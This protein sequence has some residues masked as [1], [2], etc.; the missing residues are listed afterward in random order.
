MDTFAYILTIQK[1]T[2]KIMRFTFIFIFL[3]A[4]NT[5]LSAQN[6]TLVWEDQFNGATLD[7]SKWNIENREGIWNTG[8][9]KEFQHYK[10]ENVTVGDDGNGNNCLIIT[11]KKESYNGYSYTSGRINTKGKFAFRRGKIEAL[12]KIPNLANGLW[13]AFWT[14]GYTPT[15]WPDCGEI[16][17]MEMGHAAGIAQNRQ[18]S[19]M[20]AHLFWGPYPSDYGKN[21]IASED[22]STGYFKQTAIW[23]ENKISVYFN[24]SPAPYFTMGIDGNNTEEF[25]NFQDYI[26][27]NLAIGGS[28]PGIYNESEITANLP[29]K[30]Y[31]DW[32][33]VYQETE[34]IS[35]DNLALFGTFGIFDDKSDVDMKMQ[36]GYDLSEN[37]VGLEKQNGAIPFQ[38]EHVLSYTTKADSQFALKLTAGLNRNMTNYNNGS[39]QFYLKTTS[40]DPIEIGVSDWDGNEATI[41]LANDRPQN[42][43]RDNEWHLAYLPLNEVV[44]KVDLSKLKDMLIIKGTSANDATITIDEVIYSETVPSAGYFGIY[45]NNPNIASKFNIDNITGF[46]YNWSNTVSFNSTL[47][48]YDGEDV[49]SFRSSGAANWWGIGFYSDSPLNFKNFTDGNLNLALRTKSAEN[50]TLAIQGANETKGEVQF[51]AGSDPYGFVRDGHWQTLSIPMADL[52]SQGLDLS[53]CENIFTMNGGSISDIAIDDIYLSEDGS[54]IENPNVCYPAWLEL[55]PKNIS[56]KAGRKK[57]FT[58]KIEDQFGNKTDASIEFSSDGGI[59]DEDGYFSS[60]KAGTF[61][62]WATVGD[63]VDSTTIIVEKASV[64]DQ[65]NNAIELQYFSGN[66]QL[67]ITGKSMIKTV[68]LYNLSGTQ[69]YF[70]QINDSSTKI[71][72]GHLSKSAYVINIDTENGVLRKKIA[73]W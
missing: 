50:F 72:L 17:I 63:L 43:A 13:P 37:T 21:F 66:K 53:S 10:T 58:V 20:G 32:V 48:A 59:I 51:K 41:T 71:D 23:T 33:K 40:T 54:T 68:T 7:S 73:N 62:V 44:S 29:A 45:T 34:D 18:N 27:F 25:R 12:I 11:A 4:L 55:S 47:S 9:N 49:L 60:D 2:M 8:A 6:Y 52:T 38:G 24:D 65:I 36:L 31:V 14:L 15:G 56:V 16:D 22:L 39:I 1:V 70:K 3:F 26:I 35:T 69:V 28:V 61:N 57:H 46:L 67:Q 64:V 30:I 19:Y 42:V 5:I